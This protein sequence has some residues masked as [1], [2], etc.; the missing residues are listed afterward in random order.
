MKLT[1]PPEKQPLRELQIGI[2]FKGAQQQ[3]QQRDAFLGL[4]MGLTG[5]PERETLMWLHM[6][7]TPT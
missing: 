2:T 1:G 6:G 4:Q 5:P 3:Q 7:R